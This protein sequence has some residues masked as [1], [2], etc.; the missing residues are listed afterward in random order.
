M[1]AFFVHHAFFISQLFGFA[2]LVL[3]V[4]RFTRKSR[5]S[6]LLWGPPVSGTS[7][8]S[9][10]LDLQYQGAAMSSVSMLTAWIQAH[11]GRPDQVRLRR[12][13]VV[14]SCVAGVAIAP[15]TLNPVTLLPLIFFIGGRW[16]ESLSTELR[17]RSVWLVGSVLRILYFTWY[18]N[19][20]LMA[21]ETLVLLLS[22]RRVLV[23]MRER[24]E[25]VRDASEASGALVAA[26][27]TAAT[28]AD[29]K[30]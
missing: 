8:V 4:F 10:F 24:P 6:V 28:P 9:Q 27:A 20:M 17:L 26:A 25:G 14:L 29:S 12:S 16:G 19:F 13:L 7:V 5:K 30:T 1:P 11:L 2:S 15:P 3:N 18:A 21:S 23:L 22:L